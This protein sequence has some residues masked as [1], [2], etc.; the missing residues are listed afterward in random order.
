MIETSPSANDKVAAMAIHIAG[1]FFWFV[2]SLIVY[3][4]VTG[5]P[6]LKEQARNALNFQLTMLI[7]FIIGIVL[8]FIGIGFLI[9][10]AVEVIVVVLS[11]VAAVKA[12][13]GETYKYPLTVELVK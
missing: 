11:I 10:W 2:P 5:N 1:I 4:A 6:W 13:Q 3:L 9:I 12:N 8:S 7:A